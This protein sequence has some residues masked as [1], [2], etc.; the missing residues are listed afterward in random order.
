MNEYFVWTCSNP[1]PFVGDPSTEF[2]EAQTPEE[3]LG[4]VRGHYKHPCELY[5]AIVYKD[6]TDYHKQ[7]T[8]LCEW[9][10]EVA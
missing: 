9:R 5:S 1:A 6:A 4:L 8:P 7:R 10:K 3:A 2:V